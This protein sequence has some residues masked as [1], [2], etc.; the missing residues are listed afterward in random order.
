[1]M[2]QG[3]ANLPTGWTVTHLEDVVEILDSRRI[4]VNKTERSKRV[5]EIPYYGAT[6]QV[7]WIDDYLFDEELILL[8]ADGAP[9]Y[10]STKVKAHRDKIPLDLVRS[11]IVQFHNGH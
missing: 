6:G 10:D 1:M 7:G 3:E 4:P 2:K 5:G 11:L 9:F 8:G